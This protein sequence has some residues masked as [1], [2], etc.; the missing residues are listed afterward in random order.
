MARA[1]VESPPAKIRRWQSADLNPM[2]RHD[3]RRA[4]GTNS[5]NQV[6]V[7][8][9]EQAGQIPAHLGPQTPV[10]I[11]PQHDPLEPPV[12][13]PPR[14]VDVALQGGPQVREIAGDRRLHQNHRGGALLCFPHRC[15]ARS[16]SPLRVLQQLLGCQREGD[17]RVYRTWDRIEMWSAGGSFYIRANDDRS[18]CVEL[19]YQEANNAHV[20]E[21]VLQAAYKQGV[22][23]LSDLLGSGGQSADDAGHTT[24]VDEALRKL[25]EQ[26]AEAIRAAEERSSSL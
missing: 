18:A 9:V 12:E 7:L 2:V 19:S 23:R 5:G 20:L 22:E 26:A 16:H 13:Q 15:L 17:E 24:G 25:A 6:R 10:L 14:F 8:E 21:A 11:P 3:M 4:P 1:W